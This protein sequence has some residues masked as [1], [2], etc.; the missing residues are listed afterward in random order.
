MVRT[1]LAVMLCGV[2]VSGAEAQSLNLMPMPAKVQ[3][4]TGQLVIDPNFSVSIAVTTSRGWTEQSSFSLPSFA[5]R[6]ECL[7]ST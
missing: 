4:G 2:F 1:I 6:P 3:T 7:P 5:A